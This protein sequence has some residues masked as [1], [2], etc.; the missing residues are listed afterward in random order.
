MSLD[1]IKKQKAHI[2]KEKRK[3]AESIEFSQHPL[4]YQP[5]PKGREAAVKENIKSSGRGALDMAGKIRKKSPGKFTIA[6]DR[7][8]AAFSVSRWQPTTSG[9]KGRHISDVF[10]PRSPILTQKNSFT[11]LSQRNKKSFQGLLSH[12]SYPGYREKATLKI[13]IQSDRDEIKKRLGEGEEE[14][15]KYSPDDIL[16]LQDE[17]RILPDNFNPY[18]TTVKLSFMKAEKSEIKKE[19]A[20]NEKPK[21]EKKEKG[22]KGRNLEFGILNLKQKPKS[23]TLNSKFKIR[24]PIPS[25]VPQN[26]K[27]IA[28]EEEEVSPANIINDYIPAYAP[29]AQPA[30]RKQTKQKVSFKPFLTSKIQKTFALLWQKIRD[31]DYFSRQRNQVVAMEIMDKTPANYST[32]YQ[33]E[34]GDFS[35]QS[36]SPSSP[37]PLNPPDQSNS[38]TVAETWSNQILPPNEELVIREAAEKTKDFWRVFKNIFLAFRSP[39]AKRSAIVLGIGIIISLMIPLGAYIQK[40]IEAKNRIEEQSNEAYKNVKSAKSAMISAKPEEARKNFESAYQNFLNANKSLDEIG[41]SMLSI[42]KV[43]PGG[44]KVKSGEN[45]LEAGKHLAFAGQIISESFD[46]FLGNEGALKKKFFAVDNLSTLKEASGFKPAGRSDHTENLTSAIVVFQEKL[47]RAKGELEQAASYLNRIKIGDLPEEKREEFVLLQEKLPAVVEGINNFSLSA[48][49]ILDVLGHKVA[50]QY[51]FLFQNNDEIR[52]TGGF[53]GTYG[54]LKIEEGN[55]SQL[56]IDGIYNPDGQLKERV[57]PPKPIQ[58]MSATWSMHDANWW[59]DFPKSAEKVAWFYEKTGGPAVDGVIAFTP[60]L[61]RELLKIT[62]PINHEK[63]GTV[64]TAENFVEVTQNK[65]EVEYDKKLNRPKQFLAD[66]APIILEKI[67]SSPP[68]KWIEIMSVFSDCL[69]SRSIV[70]Y[71]FDYNIQKT[72]SDLG[73]S[74]E[75]LT[76]PKDYFSVVNANIS[77]L[78][79]DRMVEQKISHLAEIKPDGSIVDT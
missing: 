55:V 52:A 67:F 23:E 76:T 57:I 11:D 42:I 22:K 39:N 58:K 24:D 71:F 48:N 17:N 79:T 65:V 30:P 64:V 2:R 9:R 32:E 43:L 8:S 6:P 62:G 53:I 4:A 73:W 29:P 72:I 46:V 19:T 37:N 77:G 56:M 1:L 61:L 26:E 41:G 63:Y 66:L 13:K 70:M 74:G 75:I 35:S 69:E 60:K 31:K 59:P 12:P 21:T 49:T 3:I 40:V 50:K 34:A 54:I 33:I 27:Y 45:L 78:K 20:S 51:L 36:G 68:E 7:N 15:P 44:S 18:G 47:A 5:T 25:V 16:N 14:L 10:V 38:P 28:V